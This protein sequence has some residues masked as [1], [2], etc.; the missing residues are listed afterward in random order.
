MTNNLVDL[1]AVMQGYIK[2]ED[3]NLEGVTYDGENWYLFNRGNNAHK[4][5]LFTLH[6]KIK[7]SFS[8]FKRLS[9]KMKG[10]RTCFTDAVL[11]EIYFL[12]P[13]MLMMMAKSWEV[14]LVA[15]TLKR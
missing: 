5:V 13:L 6:K 8:F 9:P 3:F 1:Y 4:N 10:V 7:P 14:L 11:V 2:S 15:L 12:A